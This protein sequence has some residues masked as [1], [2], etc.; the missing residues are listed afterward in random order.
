MEYQFDAINVGLI[1]ADH[2][3]KSAHRI[4]CLVRGEYF[5]KL[6]PEN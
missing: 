6:A 2:L 3:A 1:S 5:F 4:Y